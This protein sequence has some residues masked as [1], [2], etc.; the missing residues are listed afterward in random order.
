MSRRTIIVVIIPL[1]ALC[2]VFYNPALFAAQ[3]FGFWRGPVMQNDP[4]PTDF[5]IARLRYSNN[6]RIGSMGWAHNYPE[7]EMN[8]NDFIRGVTNIQVERLSYRIVNLSSEE[9]FHYPFAF[10]SEPGEMD[11]TPKEVVQLREYVNRGGFLLIDDFDG[12][13]QFDNFR[14]QMRQVF[15]EQDLQRL[16]IAHPVFSVLYEIESLTTFDP[17]VSGDEPI[18]F[19]LNRSDGTLA[20]VAAFNNDLENFWDWIG[21]PY[22]PLRPA[23]EAFRLGANFVVYSMTH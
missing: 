16:T 3:I 23:T 12:A 11:L 20:V 22:Y 13:W 9:V 17:Y 14:R 18:F 7:G 19:G 5:I 2:F 4:P 10:V 8:L 1:A 15:P 21:S 6:G